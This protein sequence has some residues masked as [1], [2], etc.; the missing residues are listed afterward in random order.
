MPDV[1]T[2]ALA[3][4]SKPFFK[5]VLKYRPAK[6]V[7]SAQDAERR[8]T[9]LMSQCALYAPDY[10]FAKVQA[11]RAKVDAAR[12]RAKASTWSKDGLRRVRI[13]YK[14]YSKATY[15]LELVASVT[16]TAV[17][18]NGP[19][20]QRVSGRAHFRA[21]TDPGSSSD[22]VMS[23]TLNNVILKPGANTI[24]LP[25]QA[26]T[27]QMA[28]IQVTMRN[29]LHSQ[30]MPGPSRSSG[31]DT[32]SDDGESIS[33]TI[34]PSAEGGSIDNDG[35][36]NGESSDDDGDADVQTSIRL[37]KRMGKQRLDVR[38][39]VEPSASIEIDVTDLENVFNDG[40]F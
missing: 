2:A 30:S 23:I 4:S 25:V 31:E 11:V 14:Y 37:S 15:L 9:E 39:D 34:T 32:R 17:R 27:P 21:P 8:V 38:G 12:E 24:E 36:D 7:K 33:V 19:E 35:N 10:E 22:G 26:D 6:L 29:V 20:G 18:Q 16:E 3:A 40:D 5:V 28:T 1:P 13:T